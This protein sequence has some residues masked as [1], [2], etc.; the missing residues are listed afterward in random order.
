MLLSKL[1]SR[2]I[3]GLGLIAHGANLLLLGSGG[4]PGSPP[5]L[6]GSTSGLVSDPLE[7]ALVLTAIV[8]TFGVTAFL[9]ALA[10]RSW[11]ETGLDEVE[12]DVEDRRIANR[13]SA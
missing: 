4:E 11:A 8:I 13:W 3:V 1:L 9:L 6:D 5:I 7:Q 12:D 2:I 10:H